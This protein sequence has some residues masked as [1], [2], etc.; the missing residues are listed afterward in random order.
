MLG[1][2]ELVYIVRNQAGVEPALANSQPNPILS[3]LRRRQRRLAD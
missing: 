1:D 3:Y 2:S